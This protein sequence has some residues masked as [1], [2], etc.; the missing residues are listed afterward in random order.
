MLFTYV[1]SSGL[2]CCSVC[3]PKD[4][5]IEKVEQV[6]NMENPTGISSR[7]KVSKDVT[8][9]DGITTNPCPCEKDPDRIHYLMNC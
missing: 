4:F 1:Y 6:V 7:W 3:V 2:A 5:A 9:R 8:F